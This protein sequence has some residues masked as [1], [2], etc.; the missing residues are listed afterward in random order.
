MAP[1]R[2]CLKCYASASNQNSKRESVKSNKS[3]TNNARLEIKSS[4]GHSNSLP[5]H[6]TCHNSQ[7]SP[8]KPKKEP[9]KSYKT[10]EVIEETPS[11]VLP[12]PKTPEIR[13][14]EDHKINYFDEPKV[15][16]P[17]IEDLKIDDSPS[18][19]SKK[20][21]EDQKKGIKIMTSNPDEHYELIRK[22]GEGGSGSVFLAKKKRTN[23]NFALKRI[24]L[25]S[26]QQRDQI[27]NEI[28]LTTLSQNP[29]VV[30][31]YESYSFNSC[32]WIIVELMKGNLTDL[33]SD[34][35]GVIPEILMAY[36]L[37]EILTGLMWMHASYRLHRDIKSDNILLSLDGAV[38]LGDF[39]Y[40]AQL[41]AEQDKRTT[42]V[43]TPSWMAP[44]LVIGSRYDGKVDIW[45]L[46][47]VSLEMAEGEP[48]NLRENPM[49]ALYLTATGPP[50]SLSEKSRWSLEFNSFV[51][52]CLTKDP[53]RR[54]SAE[55]LLNDPF[56][57]LTP[58]DAKQQFSTYLNNW[59]N[60]KRKK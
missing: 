39:G 20:E 24:P 40:A 4:P 11:K 27:L 26:Q 18:L 43:G 48:P 16:E 28:S 33:I 59:V 1:K 13:S 58:P 50:P 6:E 55:Q 56:I 23:E 31:Y 8:S 15:R 34:K 2:Y 7:E 32:L 53:E 21:F 57:L 30:S 45:S 9:A 35:A 12:T 60:R 29:N 54:P 37:K 51:E 19:P 25:K 22:I 47:I 42:V 14:N 5:V 44:E 36:I 41:T 10:H 3:D 46:G 49:K 52:K 38:K 17:R